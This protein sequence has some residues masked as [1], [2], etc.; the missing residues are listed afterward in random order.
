MPVQDK[1]QVVGKPTEST[2]LHRTHEMP[3][4]LE[5]LNGF[6]HRSSRALPTGSQ[7]SFQ[8]SGTLSWPNAIPN[9]LYTA[10]TR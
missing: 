2:S 7:N 1:P 4:D 9:A 3:N 8:N 10:S 5:M 6:G